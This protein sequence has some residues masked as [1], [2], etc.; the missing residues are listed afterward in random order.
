MAE[1][2]EV[3]RKFGVT[4]ETAQLFETE[5][6]TLL[7]GKMAAESGWHRVQD[8]E[9]A[10]QMLRELEGKTLGKLLRH[11]KSDVPLND[12]FLNSLEKGLR[13]R[14]SLFHGFFCRHNTGILDDIGRDKMLDELHVIHHDLMDAWR[15][16]GH[17]VDAA[18]KYLGSKTH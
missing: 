3:Y 16:A 6:V 14:N 12:E 7:L 11:L 17:L 1:A 9:A 8:T 18:M 15:R 4:A 13:A 10:G 2:D 5:L